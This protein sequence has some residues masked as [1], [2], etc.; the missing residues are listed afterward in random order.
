MDATC[1]D[2]K[3]NNQQILNNTSTT[4]LHHEPF[5]LIILSDE[6]KEELHIIVTNI[7]TEVLFKRLQ[8]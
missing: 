1:I 2:S 6:Y 8:F 5:M 4:W 3:N 7:S